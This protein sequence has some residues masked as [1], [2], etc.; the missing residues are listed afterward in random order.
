MRF[1]VIDARKAG[2][3]LYKPEE[4]TSFFTGTWNWFS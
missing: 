2:K 3:K 4:K 1:D